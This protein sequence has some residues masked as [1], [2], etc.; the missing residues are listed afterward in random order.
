MNL[1]IRVPIGTM[2]S[3]IGL[4]LFVYGLLTSGSDIYAKHSL[5]INMNLYWGLIMVVFG[6]SMFIFGLKAQSKSKEK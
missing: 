4:V 1:D 6:G 5:G 3:L 2:F